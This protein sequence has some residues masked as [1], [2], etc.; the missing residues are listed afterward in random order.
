MKRKFTYFGVTTLFATFAMAQLP[1]STTPQNK[2]VVLEEFTGINCQY[3]PDGHKIANNIKASKP[4]GDVI[5]VN[6]HTGGYANPSAGQPDYRT[7]DGNAIAAIP[8][9]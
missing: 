9:L 2:K 8:E 4:A 3:C 7:A 1:V 6:I 5:L